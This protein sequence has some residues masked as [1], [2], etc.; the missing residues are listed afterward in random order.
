MSVSKNKAGKASTE[1]APVPTEALE[2]K[3]SNVAIEAFKPENAAQIKDLIK[4]NFGVKGIKLADLDRI[5]V[6]TPPQNPN[7]QISWNLPTLFDDD[8][9]TTKELRMVILAWN[10]GK[11]WWPY[12]F[13]QEVDGDKRPK[14]RSNDTIF[15]H[16]DP[17][18][19]FN[20][21]ELQLI[22]EGKLERIV[23]NAQGGIVC[24]TC[25]HN[26]FGTAEE[27]DG[28]A[29][30]DMRFFIVMLEN[31][32][33]PVVLRAP[34]TSIRGMKDYF[35]RLTSNRF[36]YHQ[37]MTSFTLRREMG[38]PNKNIAYSAIEAKAIRPLT[39]E[40][41][42]AA[43]SYHNEF[44]P[45]LEEDD[46]FDALTADKEVKTEEAPATAEAA[47]PQP[48]NKAPQ[49]SPN[50]DAKEYAEF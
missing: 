3:P 36:Q 6:P 37:V 7:Q 14:C 18:S 33:L 35:K 49:A 30:R 44:Q 1:A 34:A 32:T 9:A 29:C 45:L 38:G 17:L 12:K 25:P 21:K 48:E 40:E 26:Q 39:E 13:G 27:G 47:A 23:S 4:A 11:G 50:S 41:K 16:G 5:T 19:N 46:A 15:G 22:E 42:V 43:L 2:V 28:K 24:E 20:R 31:G 8:A 10:D